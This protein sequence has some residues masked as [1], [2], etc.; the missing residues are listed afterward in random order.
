MR[1]RRGFTYRQEKL[2]GEMKLNS[3]K[4]LEDGYCNDDIDTIVTEDTHSSRVGS[5]MIRVW[6]LRAFSLVLYVPHVWV[7]PAKVFVTWMT[8]SRHAVEMTKGMEH[9]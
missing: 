4:L 7:I 1:D 2:S 3:C 9:L 8:A 6:V 5:G